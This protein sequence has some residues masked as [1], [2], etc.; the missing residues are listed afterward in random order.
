MTTLDMTLDLLHSDL[1]F[2]FETSVREYMSVYSFAL[3][4]RNWSMVNPIYSKVD[5]K[6]GFTLAMSS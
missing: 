6:S 1:R 5:S 2:H 3:S 4:I